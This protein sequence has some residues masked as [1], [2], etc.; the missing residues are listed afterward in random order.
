LIQLRTTH[1]TINK[2]LHH[3]GKVESPVCPCCH[4]ADET[5]QH[6]LLE[7]PAHRNAQHELQRLGGG[8]PS[9]WI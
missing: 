3:I 2:H 8:T 9:T 1:C 4:L 6:Y 7:C 5:V